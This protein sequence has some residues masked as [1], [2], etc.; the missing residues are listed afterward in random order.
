[1]PKSRGLAAPKLVG[2]S[3]HTGEVKAMERKAGRVD[4][5]VTAEEVRESLPK[6]KL[7]AEEEKVLRMRHGVAADPGESLPALAPGGSPVADELLLIEMELLKAQQRKPRTARTHS[8]TAASTLP[9]LDPT[10]Q[11]TRDKI[12]RALRKKK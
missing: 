1:M 9:K 10:A 2:R 4:V 11:K 7:S 6:A 5:L 12:L 3:G 8:Q